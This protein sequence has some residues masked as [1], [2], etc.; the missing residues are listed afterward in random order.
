MTGH[1]YLK[2]LQI[3]QYLIQL[4]NDTFKDTN[5]ILVY[6]WHLRITAINSITPG[7]ERQLAG[8]LLICSKLCLDIDRKTV[9]TGLWADCKKNWSPLWIG[10]RGWHVLT[11]FMP[12]WNK[13]WTWALEL[14]QLLLITRT[15]PV[16]FTNLEQLLQRWPVLVS[17]TKIF[18]LDD[19]ST[20]T[21]SEKLPT[22][23]TDTLGNQASSSD[24]QWRRYPGA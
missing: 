8:Y 19:T 21:V 4:F 11:G 18:N 22:I 2:C 16:V 17:G 14:R 13:T 15:F 9:E 20:S 1:Q 23:I 6:E 12:S 7:Q 5:T 3:I 10:K 24:Y